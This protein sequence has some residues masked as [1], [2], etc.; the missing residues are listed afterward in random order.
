[1]C[2]PLVRSERA[3]VLEVLTA[4]GA[5]IVYQ[6]EY[7]EDGWFWRKSNENIIA[8]LDDESAIEPT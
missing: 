1:M 5:R 6:A 7:N 4:T 2:E 3:P 8:V